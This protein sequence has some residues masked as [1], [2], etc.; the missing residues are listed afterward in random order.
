MRKYQ[1]EVLCSQG[2]CSHVQQVMSN[3]DFRIIPHERQ[4]SSD[5]SA[6]RMFENDEEALNYAKDLYDNNSQNIENITILESQ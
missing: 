4:L 2:M 5:H 3:M 1:F 6:F